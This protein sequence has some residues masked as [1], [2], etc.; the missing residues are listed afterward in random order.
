MNVDAAVKVI[1]ATQLGLNEA[2]ITPEKK[3]DY[4]G[5]DSLDLVEIVMAAEDEFGVVISDA[6]AEKISTVGDLIACVTSKGPT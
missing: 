3:L 1:L 6:E 5:A 4:L 2:E